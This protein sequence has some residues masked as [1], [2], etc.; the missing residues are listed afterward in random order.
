MEANIEDAVATATLVNQLE[1]L[2]QWTRIVAD[3]SEFETLRQFKPEDATTNPTLILKAAENPNYRALVERAVGEAHRVSSSPSY[4]ASNLL[5]AFG[6]EILA[7]VPGRVSTE[8]SARL[9]FDSESLIQQGRFFIALYERRGVPRERVLIKLASTWEGIEAAQVLESEGIHCNMTLMFSLAQAAA[10]AEAGATLI[11]P[12][13]GRILDW[14]RAKN[15]GDYPPEVDPGVASV[16]EIYAYYKRHRY[17][18]EVMGASFRNKGEILELAGCDALTISPQLLG[19][20]QN[21]VDPIERKVRAEL[22]QEC[23]IPKLVMDEGMFRWLLNADAMA[24]E[25][26]AE[27]IRTF[28]ADEAK[29]EEAI[30]GWQ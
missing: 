15:G 2:R 29:L 11:S 19:D 20:L 10:S 3:S 13:V 27:G 9:A 12:F 16:K 14:H 18:T 24:T 30:K 5:V 17:S 6:A 25:K 4:I 7:I 26:L 21:S 28:A 8:T 22:G 1:Q 23:Q